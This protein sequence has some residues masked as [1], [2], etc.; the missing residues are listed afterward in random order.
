MSIVNYSGVLTYDDLTEIYEN[1][2][3]CNR[4]INYLLLTEILEE[5][6]DT[7]GNEFYLINVFRIVLRENIIVSKVFIQEVS[8]VFLQEVIKN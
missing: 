1:G 7:T 8:K 4:R 6:Y 3:D 5:E 2:R